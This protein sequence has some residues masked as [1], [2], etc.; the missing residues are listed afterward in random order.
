MAS[1]FLP[2]VLPQQADIRYDGDRN[3]AH[4]LV[5]VINGLG[6]EASLLSI[7]SAAD[8]H[9]TAI[10]LDVASFQALS[11]QSTAAVPARQPATDKPH[12]GSMTTG[13]DTSASAAASAL[14]S[15]TIASS[16]SA[17]GVVGPKKRAHAVLYMVQ[18]PT[19]SAVPRSTP[20]RRKGDAMTPSRT[21]AVLNGAYADLH[22]D[23]DDEGGDDPAAES[24]TTMAPVDFADAGVQ[25]AALLA[26]SSATPHLH[27]GFD[28]V[29]VRRLVARLEQTLGPGLIAL[30]IQVDLFFLF[31]FFPVFC[32]RN[33]ARSIIQDI[34]IT[35]DVDCYD[36]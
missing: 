8:L 18:T 24:M 27:P 34:F 1:V 28:L 20:Y 23:S 31:F 12:E 6:F 22:V 15:T 17:T 16:V 7:S 29:A 19:L 2:S 9:S 25:R 13:R 33:L 10:H 4:H 32:H 26:A 3:L 36:I 21:A 14:S 35:L 5:Q 11:Q 30:D